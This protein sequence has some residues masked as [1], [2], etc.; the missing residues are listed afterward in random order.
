MERCLPMNYTFSKW[1]ILIDYLLMDVLIILSCFNYELVTLA[2]AWTAQLAIS[3]GF[4]YWKAKN[5]N[6]I[7]IP[8]EIIKSMDGLQNENI[9]LTQ[10]IT[11]LID[12]D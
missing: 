5:E 10:I 3:T 11:T 2:I 4:Y 12:K 9:D 7:K 6:R 8:M 1:M